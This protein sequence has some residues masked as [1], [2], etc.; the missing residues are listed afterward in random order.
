LNNADELDIALMIEE[1]T[2]TD[3]WKI[4]Q[5]F[6]EERIDDNKQQLMRCP[7]ENVMEHRIRAE[8][9]QSILTHVKDLLVT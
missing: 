6:I 4:V 2:E 5:Q 7:I 3:G 8:T 9:Y 1:M